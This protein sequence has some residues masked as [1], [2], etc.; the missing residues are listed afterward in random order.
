MKDYKGIKIIGVDNG[1]GNI[2]TASTVTR[3]G[4]T[5]HAFEPTFG[6]NVL[7]YNGMYYRIGE[8]HKSFIA[9]KV[10]DEDFYLLTLAA[11]A[12]ELNQSHITEADVHLAA[13][14][15]LTWVGSQR[16]EFR[17][18]LLKNDEARFNYK[19]KDYHIRFVGCSIFPQGYSAI[20]NRLHEMN[21]VNMLADIGNGTINIMYIIDRKP[22]ESKCWT[23]KLGVNQCVIAAR[24]KVMDKFG[25]KVE[26]V[27]IES[28]IRKG[29][30]DIGEDYLNCII[31]AIKSYTEEVFQTLHKYEYNPNLM[32][33][34]VVGGGGCIIKNFADYNKE[35]V[36]I[37]DDICATAKGYEIL[38]ES[39]LRKSR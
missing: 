16:E 29:T 3:T 19:G 14:L 21:G 12:R 17:K 11:I 1:Y 38:A 8:S 5:T 34:H 10:T 6:G 15:P 23:E 18:Y 36:I 37:N 20:I 31:A 32:K 22:I 39:T 7:K 9:D 13:G 28:V 27:I 30:A 35:R 4:I 26:D 24:N 33:L 2:K 25:V